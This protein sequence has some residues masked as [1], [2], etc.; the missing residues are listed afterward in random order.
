[1]IWEGIVFE[2]SFRLVTSGLVRRWMYNI[3]NQHEKWYQKIY[4]SWVSKL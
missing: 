4:P 1:M 3:N 2:D